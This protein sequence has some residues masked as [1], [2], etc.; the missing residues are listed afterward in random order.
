[1]AGTVVLVNRLLWRRMYNLAAT[2]FKLE[3]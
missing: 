1:M 2:K 3:T